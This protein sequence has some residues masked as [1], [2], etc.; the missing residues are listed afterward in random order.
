VR[1]AERDAAFAEFVRA[2]R[3]HLR[4]VAYAVCGDWHRADDLV[5]TTLTK[6]LLHWSRVRAATDMDQYVRAIL[7]KAFL[8]ERGRL[9]SK[10][11]LVDAVPERPGRPAGDVEDRM[12]LRAALSRLPRRQQ[13]VIVLRFLCDLSV[14]EAAE[15]LRCAPGTVKSQTHHGL[16][17]L[18]A[19]L[20]EPAAVLNERGN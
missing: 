15:V 9:W 10:V 4:R 13:A 12:V 16:T 20:G 14:Q 2:R 18:R 11:R 3:T 6:V 17:A 5:Q 1:A 7:V 19:A 8:T